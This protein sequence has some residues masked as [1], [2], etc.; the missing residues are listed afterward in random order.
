MI[1]QDPI[2]PVKPLRLSLRDIVIVGNSAYIWYTLEEDLGKKWCTAYTS[3]PSNSI[4]RRA[5]IKAIGKIE[6]TELN[7]YGKN[8]YSISEGGYRFLKLLKYL[9]LRNT[10]QN[11]LFK[12]YLE[13]NIN[14]EELLEKLSKYQVIEEL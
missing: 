11:K 10:E 4:K 8:I 9:D 12:E 13:D 7:S 2:Y 1:W 3:A 5:I 14:R 6:L